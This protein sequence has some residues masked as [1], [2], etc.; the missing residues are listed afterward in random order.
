M[1]R[2]QLLAS[3]PSNSLAFDP[4]ADVAAIVAAA[5]HAPKATASSAFLMTSTVSHGGM[6][7][8]RRAVAEATP[9]QDSV[10][11]L[12]SKSAEDGLCP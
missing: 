8:L 9:H 2:K 1:R 11:A 5:A 7:V 12:S 10:I 3:G 6:Y 4:H